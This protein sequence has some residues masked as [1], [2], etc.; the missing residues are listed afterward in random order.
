MNEASVLR[1][2]LPVRA[3]VSSNIDSASRDSLS[4]T[5]GGVEVR[6]MGT[7]L[8]SSFSDHLLDEDED[9]MPSLQTSPQRGTLLSPFS[10][11][12]RQS[13]LN[14]DSILFSLQA[15]NRPVNA[16]VLVQPPSE[17]SLKE[18]QVCVYPIEDV[19]KASQELIVVNP[20][21]LGRQL[22]SKLTMETARLVAQSS[23]DWARSFCFSQIHWIP[24][25]PK[26][27]PASLTGISRICRA[28]AYDV[29]RIGSIATRTLLGVGRQTLFGNV[30]QESVARV[31]STPNDTASDLTLSSIYQ[32]YGVLGC[33]VNHIL[34]QK[35]PGMTVTIG[36]LH[37]GPEHLHD[38]L[39]AKPFSGKL[40][41]RNNSVSGLS[42]HPVDS[43]KGL[44]HLVRRALQAH[45][46]RS[47]AHVLA[48]IR[49]WQ[50]PDHSTKLIVGDIWSSQKTKG[51]DNGTKYRG[52][53]E[54]EKRRRAVMNTS[55]TVLGTVLRNVLLRHAG[56][57]VV[58]SFRESLLTQALR[59]A[60]QRDDAKTVVLAG[61]S[62]LS[63][64]Y[65]STLQTLR[66]ASRLNYQPIQAS[67]VSPFGRGTSK[68][69]T[70]P[71]TSTASSTVSPSSTRR[72][73]GP[74]GQAVLETLG[75]PVYLQNMISDP[76]QRLAKIGQAPKEVVEPL[77]NELKDDY[78]PT[79]YQGAPA[80][81]STRDDL[82]KSSMPSA[83][84]PIRPGTHS[85]M[86]SDSWAQSMFN[87]PGMPTPI[88]DNGGKPRN[89][90]SGYRRPRNHSRPLS[91]A[92]P[93][94][95][96]LADDSF[97]LDSM[98][99]GGPP[100]EMMPSSPL[101]TNTGESELVAS[102]TWKTAEN[103]STSD[104]DAFRNSNGK[105][106]GREQI[107]H[108]AG[109]GEESDLA[110][111]S[112]LTD[113]EDSSKVPFWEDPM[114]ALTETMEDFPPP[115]SHLLAEIDP[116]ATPK[117]IRHT[118]RSIQ[119][120]VLETAFSDSFNE[121]PHSD[122]LSRASQSREV[123]SQRAQL[124]V[125]LKERDEARMELAKMEQSHNQ[126]DDQIKSQHHQLAVLTT[127]RDTVKAQLGVLRESSTDAVRTH[128]ERCSKLKGDLDRA[129]ARVKVESDHARR[130]EQTRALSSEQLNEENAKLKET[131]AATAE[132]LEEV[133]VAL[134]SATQAET[135][136][137]ECENK[138][139]QESLKDR[140]AALAHLEN[141]QGETK[142]QLDRRSAE[143]E[144]LKTRL[145]NEVSGHIEQLEANLRIA[146]SERDEATHTLQS[147]EAARAADEK[148]MARQLA[149]YKRTVDSQQS[150]LEELDSHVTDGVQK[151]KM[152]QDRV[153][154][155]TEERDALVAKLSTFEEKEAE[156]RKENNE[157]IESIRVE[158]DEAL[159]LLRSQDQSHAEKVF[160]LENE[161]NK[162][163]AAK[164]NR[165]REIVQLEHARSQD[166]TIMEQRLSLIQKLELD[167]KVDETVA[168]ERDDA[169][170]T[171]ESLQE[172]VSRNASDY[173]RTLTE[174]RSKILELEDSK[175]EIE[176]ERLE[177]VKIA[178]EAIATQAALEQK[179]DS[180]EVELSEARERSKDLS[181]NEDVLL[182]LRAEVDEYK[183]ELHKQTSTVSEL[184]SA[185]KALEMERE[186]LLKQKTQAETSR[187]ELLRRF[188]EV[189]TDPDGPIELRKQ[190]SVVSLDL[191]RSQEKL[192]QL[193]HT[194]NERDRRV[195]ELA[196]SELLVGQLT[197]RLQSSTAKLQE[198]D[199]VLQSLK[200]RLKEVDI[201]RQKYNDLLQTQEV[202]RDL[203]ATV[204]RLR[205]DNRKYEMK[206]SRMQIALKKVQVTMKEQVEEVAREHSNTKVLIEET[207]DENRILS[208]ENDRLS[209]TIEELRIECRVPDSTGTRGAQSASSLTAGAGRTARGVDLR[210]TPFLRRRPL[211]SQRGGHVYNELEGER[212]EDRSS[213]TLQARTEE[214]AAYL[215]LSSQMSDDRRSDSVND[216]AL[217]VNSI[218][219]EKDA[220]IR[221]LK[222][223][224]RCLE[225]W[226]DS[227][228]VY[229]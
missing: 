196:N 44:G 209:R 71:T 7:P 217:R 131:L 88:V 95:D 129:L 104:G 162:Q 67:A 19:T 18:T 222:D 27:A 98:E 50:K 91:P 134:R 153:K 9:G 224:I 59:D 184:T 87:N 118:S 32:K 36:F 76:R 179:V 17:L 93:F 23:E 188:E 228:N 170:R 6:G 177:V 111:G 185:I 78:S 56:N 156:N 145:E 83:L 61:I 135:T 202:N 190:L 110:P 146:Y 141:T 168:A 201:S 164:E 175:S 149:E 205:E 212:F 74:L 219:Y 210:E 5:L 15:S 165:E 8:N 53:P 207:T 229:D 130:F 28:A 152:Q 90:R 112:T 189:E 167:Q 84:S 31:L 199:Q 155:L 103:A 117:D 82:K 148:F 20:R 193:G 39:A 60:I 221:S 43:L 151:A 216:L 58:L 159:R 109:R 21:A 186:L 127:E 204:Q 40:S 108:R 102:L 195:A 160:A 191:N 47:T 16:V 72:E 10:P 100:I 37:V 137:L 147:L 169:V 66:Y 182:S 180:L 52:I 120:M 183:V 68:D 225:R 214:V 133:K 126:Q 176:R 97:T 115:P 25:D 89:P 75:S 35:S 213:Q 48:Y 227:R 81:S 4:L 77:S 173:Q 139:L 63:D 114:D 55:V 2:L 86:S 3:K 64:D 171:L 73:P 14:E 12:L 62:P 101:T 163:K 215:A 138:R 119:E 121:D 158:R 200:A 226:L 94:G 142:I 197:S 42:G 85:G 198:R 51:A 92:G 33:C 46:R 203:Q 178:E 54:K 34:M 69:S 132:E 106:Y 140:E 29:T 136:E 99:R 65:I 11:K 96:L 154:D 24:P 1:A 107:A 218:E 49:V 194:L 143:V 172:A 211:R 26:R 113:D 116:V 123:E 220:E 125:V 70:V 157:M 150:E 174:Y 57:D 13:K 223:R 22:P 206:I 181:V 166:A 80:T 105:P 208:A 122:R 161:C 30:G 45:S 41:L 124:L 79:D 187:Q 144:A 128:A 38:L 192:R